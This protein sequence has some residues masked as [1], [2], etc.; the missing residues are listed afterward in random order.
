MGTSR[1]AVSVKMEVS[2][3][4]RTYMPDWRDTHDLEVAERVLSALFEDVDIA[5]EGELMGD[6]TCPPPDV[7]EL[8]HGEEPKRDPSCQWHGTRP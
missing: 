2:F 3:L 8:L 6:C 1:N 7:A 5:W 4:L